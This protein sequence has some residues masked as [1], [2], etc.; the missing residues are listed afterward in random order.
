MQTTR[1]AAGRERDER[2]L[3]SS[4]V[5]TVYDVDHSRESLVSVSMIMDTVKAADACYRGQNHM[6]DT[7]RTHRTN[8]GY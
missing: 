5:L 7:E 6:N 1:D 2:C 3:F 8:H 4:E